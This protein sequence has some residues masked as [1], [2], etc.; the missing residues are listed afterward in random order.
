[1]PV[2]TW[3]LLL[4]IAACIPLAVPVQAAGPAQPAAPESVESAFLT[5]AVLLSIGLLVGLLA[6][7]GRAPAPP[8]EEVEP[9]ADET[10]TLTEVAFLAPPAAPVAHL[11]LNLPDGSHQVTLSGGESVLGRDPLASVVLM[12]SQASRQHA[13]IFLDGGT[14]WIEDLQSLNGTLVN[15]VAI[16]RRLLQP[17]DLIQRS[18]E[19][20][21]GKECRL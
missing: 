1:M 20:R 11:L 5:V 13:R 2:R 19:R 16:T 12:D 21:V 15:G 8:P 18:E 6:F 9:D 10:G 3:P 4:A 14:Y 17:D 7:R